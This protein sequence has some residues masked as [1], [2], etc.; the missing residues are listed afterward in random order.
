MGGTKSSPAD[1]E[2][3]EFTIASIPEKTDEVDRRIE[4]LTARIG[5]DDAVRGDIMI[6]VNEVVKNA[7]LHGNN[8]DQSKM[9]RITCICN[10]SIFRIHVCDNGTGFNPESV[11]DP[12]NPD[13]LLKEHG[14]GLLMINFLMDEVDFEITEEGT[15]VTLVK[16]SNV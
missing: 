6:A 15:R 8:C 13:N 3:I 14:R 4:H 2:V 5:Y 16:Y 12:R 9:V 1:G 10:T 7:I 11:A